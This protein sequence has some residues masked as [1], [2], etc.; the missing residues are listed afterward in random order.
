MSR[1]TPGMRDLSQRLI[2]FESK[3][4]KSSETTYLAAFHVCE[5]LRPYLATLMGSDGFRAL[6]SRALAVAG[7][8]VSWLRAVHVQANSS[9]EGGDE[10]A[11]KVAPDEIRE[12]AVVLIAQLFGLLAAFI[13]EDLMLRMV[14]EVWPKLSLDDLDFGNGETK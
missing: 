10:I 13:G 1:A 14:R 5:K 11:G 2:T 3:G 12:G 7:T 4:K 6:L 9:L 8:E